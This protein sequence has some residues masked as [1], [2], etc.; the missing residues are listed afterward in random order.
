MRRPVGDAST[1]ALTLTLTLHSPPSPSPSQVCCKG[2]CLDTP[3]VVGIAVG[4]SLGFICLVSI[5]IA[6]CCCRKKEKAPQQM[7][8]VITK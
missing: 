3:V 4:S 6:W 7:S 1:L 2:K 8:D 5:L